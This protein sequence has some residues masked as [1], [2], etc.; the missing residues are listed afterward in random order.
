[1]DVW[2]LAVASLLV[3]WFVAA[4]TPRFSLPLLGL[5]AACAAPLV[6]DWTARGRSAAL[7]WTA[8][9][10]TGVTLALSLRYHGWDVGRP[11]SRQAD[12][13]QDYPGIPAGIDAL[14]PLAIYND[15]RESESSQPSN[16][17][18]FGLDHRHLVYDHPGVAADAAAEFLARLR[19]LGADAVFIR[20]PRQ[21]AMPERYASPALEPLLR[22]EGR[23]FR[24]VLYGVR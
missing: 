2:L 11:D 24:S 6:D 4:R 18:L 10:L 22:F 3:F 19:R 7:G 9:L 1:M 23:E 14:P 16:Y 12:L 5:L 13:E 21:A 17:K 20:L 15:T 8:V